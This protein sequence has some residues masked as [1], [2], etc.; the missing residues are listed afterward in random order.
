MAWECVPS[1]AA[2]PNVGV[3]SKGTAGW[4]GGVVVTSSAARSADHGEERQPAAKTTAI[5]AKRI[6]AKQID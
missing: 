3:V 2:V 6:A 4:A 1:A 5:A